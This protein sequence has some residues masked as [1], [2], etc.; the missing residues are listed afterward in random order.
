MAYTAPNIDAVLIDFE[1]Y[2]VPADLT[3]IVIGFGDEVEPPEPIDPDWREAIPYQKVAG[4]W[5]QKQ[6]R[7]KV[8]G[9]WRTGKWYRCV[10]PDSVVPTTASKLLTTS[11]PEPGRLMIHFDKA[12][13]NRT[14]QSELVY[15]L[16][17]YYQD[18][19]D[20]QPIELTT[21]SNIDTYGILVA[22]G[23]DV[24]FLELSYLI[25]DNISYNVICRD[26][27]GNRL[28]YTAGL[29]EAPQVFQVDV[30]ITDDDFTLDIGETRQI[31]YTIDSNGVDDSVFFES[32]DPSVAS[33]GPTGIVTGVSGGFAIITVYSALASDSLD[34]VNVVV[35]SYQYSSWS[36]TSSF[37][38][39]T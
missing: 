5:R 11:E 22:S 33:V 18:D 20:L 12:I 16:W 1:P 10:N 38:T 21:L 26:K 23:I 8:D 28:L 15:E 9:I 31:N 34:T 17:A 24:H 27:A 14:Q 2:T 6:G 4:E 3:A 37:T 39:T 13:D 36:A 29:F 32:N 30:Q 19:S 35:G 7:R 25:Q